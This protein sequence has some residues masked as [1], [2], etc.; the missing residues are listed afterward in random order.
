MM[1]GPVSSKLMSFS[2]AVLVFSMP[3]MAGKRDGDPTARRSHDDVFSFRTNVDYRDDEMV[4][5]QS[6]MEG[7]M[8]QAQRVF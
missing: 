4:Q 2:L 8:Y 5:V 1:A 6:S 7:A 3:S